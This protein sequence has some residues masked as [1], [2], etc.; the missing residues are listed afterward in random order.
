M[1]AVARLLD[2][3]ARSAFVLVL[4]GMILMLLAGIEPRPEP[5]APPA[6]GSWLASLMALEPE[7]FIW[8]GIGLTA[9]LPGATVVAAAIG[10]ARAGDR[11]GA[12]TA[13][14]VLI[15]LSI[16]LVVAVWTR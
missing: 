8:A 11:R 13:A 15:A 5:T 6:A 1:T 3:G 10:F 4:A 12:M 14:G 9:I 7:A 16:A 2:V